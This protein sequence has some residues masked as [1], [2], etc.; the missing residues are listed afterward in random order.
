MKN[1]TVEA[2]HGELILKNK[3]GDHVII[4]AEKRALVSLRM[5]QGCH[6]CIDEIVNSLPVAKKYAEMGS[7]Y[8]EDDETK[9]V[10]APKVAAPF[11]LPTRQD[12]ADVY[13]SSRAAREWY[14]N[15]KNNRNRNMYAPDPSRKESIAALPA[16]LAQ[17]AAGVEGKQGRNF[18]TT[19]IENGKRSNR[20]VNPLDY[21]YP[22]E[23]RP[24]MMMSREIN[25]NIL[26]LDA[27]ATMYHSGI[28]PDQVNVYKETIDRAPDI[29][30][31]AG[32]SDKIRPREVVQQEIIPPPVVTRQDSIPL[33]PAVISPKP[34]PTDEE[35]RRTKKQH[36][37]TG[38]VSFGTSDNRPTNQ[39]GVAG[40]GQ[41]Q[42]AL[43][44]QGAVG[45]AWQKFKSLF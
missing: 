16:R 37:V 9:K 32:Y 18:T 26:N 13:E 10:V 15:Q 11:I 1:I 5:A 42:N 6:S 23:G 43:N 27:P 17:G 2:E 41:Y 36:A 4:P 28:T 25:N 45:T 19:V 38:R 14:E 3:A 24:G 35:I 7:L 21:Q 40:R 22:V 33:R 30:Q 12:S 34:R 8:P 31:L 29:V 39:P 44:G 20:V